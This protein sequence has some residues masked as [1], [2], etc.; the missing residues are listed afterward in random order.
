MVLHPI[1]LGTHPLSYFAKPP[2]PPSGELRGERAHRPSGERSSPRCSPLLTGLRPVREVRILGGSSPRQGQGEGRPS[3]RPRLGLGPPHRSGALYLSPGF[4]RP[5]KLTSLGPGGRGGSGVPPKTQGVLPP[6]DGGGVPGRIAGESL[7]KCL[8]R[9]HVI[10]V[11]LHLSLFRWC[12]SV[13]QSVGLSF[14]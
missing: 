10:L 12:N 4:V 5:P 9:I 8:G 13:G 1:R 2:I 7:G 11:L 6:P 14:H 3:S